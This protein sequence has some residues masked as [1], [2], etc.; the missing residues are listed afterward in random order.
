[1][2]MKT[3]LNVANS[4]NVSFVRL[5]IL[6]VF[7]SFFKGVN[8][9]TTLYFQG[10]ENA[11]LTC[12]E[13]WGYT[14]GTRNS[15]TDRTGS[16]S[17]MVG[18]SATS[19]MMTF[20]DV[21]VSGMAG[22]NLQIYHSVRS[23][24]GPGMDTR[25]GAVIQYRLDGGAWQ[26]LGQI[27]GFG[28]HAYAWTAATGGSG[29][30]S[31]GCNV[32]QCSNP[33]NFAIPAGTNTIAIR[34]YSV[35]L[36][37]STCAN[38]N[39]AMN[40]GAASLYDRADEGFHIDDV[41][42][43][44]TS[45]TLTNVWLGTTSQDWN[46]CS[47]WSLGIV[48]TVAHN[49]LINQSGTIA[50]NCRVFNSNAVCNNL[51]LTTTNSNTQDLEVRDNRTLAIGG[52]AI[53]TRTA[54][55]TGNLKFEAQDGGIINIT[56]DLTAT[57]NAGLTQAA[58][59][60]VQVESNSQI[61]VTGN[62]SL[63]N[64][65]N[66]TNPFVWLSLGAAGVGTGTF[67]CNNLT[68]DGNATANNSNT[69]VQFFAGNNHTFEVRGNF[70][71]QDNA[72]FNATDASSAT[73]IRFRGNYTN[74]V[75]EAQVL[76]G[77]TS[78]FTFNGAANQTISTNNFNEV[79]N[80]MTVTKSGGNVL[81]ANPLEIKSNL[82]FTTGDVNSTLA[83][84][85]IFRDN[86]THTTPSHTSHTNGPVRK[87][88]NDAFTFPVGNGTFYRSIG[89]SAP[90]NSADHFTAQFFGI[91]PDAVDGV[92]TANIEVPLTNISD[93]EHWI[94]DRT[95]GTSNVFVTLSYEDYSI[96]NCSGVT[97]P[98]SLKV[99][100]WDAVA[101]IW[102][103]HGGTGIGVPTG[104]I[105]TAAAVTAFS[106]FALST[107]HLNNALPA[108]LIHF[109]ALPKNNEVQLIWSTASEI[110]VDYFEVYRS[111]DGVSFNP[112]TSVEA[113][114]NSS[115]L[116]QYSTIDSYPFSGLSYYQ[117]KTIDNDGYSE[118][119]P[120]KS[121]QFDRVKSPY[122]VSSLADWTIFYSTDNV[123]PIL[124]EIFDATGKLVQSEQAVFGDGFYTINHT[125]FAKGMYFI[126]IIDGT[127]TAVIKAL[128]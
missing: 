4:I 103:N 18:R 30:V 93:C 108:E 80:S 35:G 45:A 32:Y 31:A 20:N 123:T 29:A 69:R 56:G 119:S 40:G 50:N 59:I 41:R 26:I 60:E 53:I 118:L 49:V 104:T 65:A 83:N 81:L 44:T 91:S 82:T 5:S 116:N 77:T 126:K 92:V 61:N 55:G 58:E 113:T 42:I 97:D 6:I 72:Q 120:I 47:N 9:Q 25:E 111:R 66:N 107:T 84:L 27:G 117:L 89:I 24:T 52:N 10:F 106:P 57:I 19:S 96:N 87:I 73:I 11:G 99:A 90:S 100:R 63:I 48:P 102:R 21:N 34:I 75:S 121:V 125:S 76:E 43:T 7:I 114:G 17:G 128:R 74:N 71:M 2:M 28:D 109:D 54:D 33:I 94:L 1:M 16:F 115:Y 46:V 15:E 112:I 51:T 85:L 38:Y 37:G 79:F 12:S 88:G 78:R 64:N 14:G 22:L 68:L 36:N 86:A 124:L 62:A 105:T 3:R 23:G 101:Q 95:S 127:N 13:N 98:V 8:C 122:I 110:N 67:N 70:L 39:T